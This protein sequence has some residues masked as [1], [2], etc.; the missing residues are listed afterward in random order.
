[1][2]V[3]ASDDQLF[4]KH[5]I[6]KL[7]SHAHH[8]S[9]VLDLTTLLLDRLQNGH[10]IDGNSWRYGEENN[11]SWDP[12]DH[13]KFIANLEH[14]LLCLQ[15]AA[16]Q[17]FISLGLGI[18]EAELHHWYHCWQQQEQFHD[19][20]YTEW[21]S[22]RRPLS[23]TWPWNIKPSLLVLWG[24]CWMFYGSGAN[25]TNERRES[26]VGRGERA[27]AQQMNCKAFPSGLPE[28]IA[29]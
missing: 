12:I 9:H 17:S 4:L 3:L 2:R 29:C 28:V 24:V 11:A 18:L 6:H 5:H 10:D 16:L 21:P 19:G 1:M 14:L 22:G 20:F 27:P 13:E 23:T 7:V 26:I 15:Q 8:A 25:Q